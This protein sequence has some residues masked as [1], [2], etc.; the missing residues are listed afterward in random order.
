MES[1]DLRGES[2]NSGIMPAPGNRGP[3][4]PHMPLPGPSVTAE[5]SL[6]PIERNPRILQAFAESRPAHA[7]GHGVQAELLGDLAR[8]MALQ[9]QRQHPLFGFVETFAQVPK[10]VV[11]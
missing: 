11:V 9:S 5:S 3:Y 4:Q 6:Q 8:R 1:S 7:Q 2:S 10:L